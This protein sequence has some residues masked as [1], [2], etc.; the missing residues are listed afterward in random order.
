MREAKSIIFFTIYLKIAKT[1]LETLES[2][3]NSTYRPSGEKITS[4]TG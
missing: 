2:N 3:K 1:F 4:Q